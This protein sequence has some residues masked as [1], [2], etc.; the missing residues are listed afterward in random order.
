MAAIPELEKPQAQ[1]IGE[2]ALPS[3]APSP[4]EQGVTQPPKQAQQQV[5]EDTTQTV[6]V[7][8]QPAAHGPAMQVP[9]D[10]QTTLTTLSKGP[11]ENSITWYA[12]FW[13]RMIKKAIHYGWRVVFRHGS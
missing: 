13:L 1:E 3:E 4:H 10:D 11:T 5:Q 8:D 12:T 6:Q 7:S 9:A 2:T